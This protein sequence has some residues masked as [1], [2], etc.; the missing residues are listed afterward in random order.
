M[1]P[2]RFFPKVFFAGRFFPPVSS[3]IP[4]FPPGSTGGGGTDGHDEWQ[5]LRD[6]EEDFFVILAGLLA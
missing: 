2:G 4:P 5:R 1:F 3:I 6:D